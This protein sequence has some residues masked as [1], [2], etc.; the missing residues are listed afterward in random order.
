MTTV[1]E[2]GILHPFEAQQRFDYRRH[3]PDQRLAPFVENFWTITWDLTGQ[4]PYT[5]QVLPYPSVNVS[6]THQEADVTGITRKRYDRHL[7]DRGYVVGAR[8]RPGCFRPFVATSVS[9]LTDRHRPIAEVLGR[10]TAEL[11][12]SVRATSD[13]EER[14]ALLTAFLVEGVPDRDP[15]AEWLADLVAQIA[16]QPEITRVAQVA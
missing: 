8:F 6:V 12:A 15:L 1:E 4:P 14:V 3:E 11:F 2:P 5:A 9:S 7:V 13:R 16:A 10:D